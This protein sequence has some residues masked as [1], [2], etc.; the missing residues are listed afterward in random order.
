MS[1]FF[2]NLV[3]G[4]DSIKNE[5]YAPCSLSI[6]FVLSLQLNW[7]IPTNSN[8]LIPISLQPDF[9]DLKHFNLI[10]LLNK[11]T[12]VW[13]IEDCHQVAKIYKLEILSLWQ[14]LLFFAF[15]LNNY[16]K[17]DKARMKLN[18]RIKLKR[19]DEWISFFT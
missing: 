19:T 16:K 1:E 6:D 9:F 10:L 8:F 4:W 7:V 12:S 14:I 2:Y 3:I 5:L 18:S 13:K 15:G 11:I 17:I